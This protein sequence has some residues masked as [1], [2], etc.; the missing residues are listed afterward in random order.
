LD[1][2]AALFGMTAPTDLNLDQ[3]SVAS[4]ATLAN[5]KALICGAAGRK[6]HGELFWTARE[7]G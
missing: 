5:A 4:L 1:D 2:A 3:T 6:R 7:L